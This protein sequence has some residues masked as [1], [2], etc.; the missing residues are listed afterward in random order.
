MKSLSSSTSISERVRSAGGLIG[1]VLAGAVAIAFLA[2][3]TASCSDSGSTAP[4][5]QPGGP[6][7]TSAPPSASVSN[8]SSQTITITG[9][10]EPY[11]IT[12]IPLAA[13]ARAVWVDSAHTPASL[14]VFGAASVAT[15]S[16]SV[17]IRDSSPSAAR[18]VTIPIIKN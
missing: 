16:T 15:G 1:G 14:T 5:G 12:Q 17:I 8:G 6:A 3:A 9:G 18:T 10:Q 2:L 13:L 4:P 11:V 7:L